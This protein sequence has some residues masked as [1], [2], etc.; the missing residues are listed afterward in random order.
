MGCPSNT[1]TRRQ[2]FSGR[3]QYQKATIRKSKSVHLA[4]T[5]SRMRTRWCSAP[6]V[7]TQ[8][9]KSACRRDASIQISRRTNKARKRLLVPSASCAIESSSRTSKWAW[10]CRPSRPPRCLLF[11]VSRG[12]SPKPKRQRVNSIRK[13]TQMSP[14]SSASLTSNKKTRK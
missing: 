12:S 13:K 9:I 3:P 5:L 1:I 11:K 4:F 6:S 7:A 14:S 2:S 10:W 8:T